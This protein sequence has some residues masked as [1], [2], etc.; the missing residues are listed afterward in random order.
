MEKLIKGVLDKYNTKRKKVSNGE[1]A[2]LVMAHIKVGIDGKKGWFLNLNS[3][4]G[5]HKLAKEVIRE[6]E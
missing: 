5:Q 3:L 1:L 6:Y 4:D 2:R